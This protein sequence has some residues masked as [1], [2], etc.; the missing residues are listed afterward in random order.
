MMRSLAVLLVVVLLAIAGRAIAHLKFIDL[1]EVD[2]TEDA[3]VYTSLGPLV[4]NVYETAKAYLGIPFATP[5]LGELRFMPTVP[6]DPWGNGTVLWAKSMQAGCPQQCILPPV[7]CRSFAASQIL[8][9]V[10]PHL[11]LPSCSR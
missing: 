5:P 1:E 8:A 11:A 7:R 6:A 9:L 4:G 10:F 2:P 3:L